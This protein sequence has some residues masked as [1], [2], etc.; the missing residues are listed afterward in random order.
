[1]LVLDHARPDAAEQPLSALLAPVDQSAAARS[2]S[3]LLLVTGEEAPEAYAARARTLVLEVSR[4]DV[5]GLGLRLGEAGHRESHQRL[6]RLQAMGRDGLFA[7]ALAGYVRWLA[8]SVDR[9]PDH[10]RA[11][12][13]ELRGAVPAGHAR[14]GGQVAQLMVGLAC[15]L[16]YARSVDPPR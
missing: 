14:T 11:E 7:Q 13:A 15:F 8:D 4:G 2:S 6:T 12:A 10:V 16:E 9:L 1:L 3:G 5:E